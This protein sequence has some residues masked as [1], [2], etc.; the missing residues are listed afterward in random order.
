MMSDAKQGRFPNGKSRGKL[1]RRELLKLGLTGAGLSF[2]DFGCGNNSGGDPYK[3]PPGPVSIYKLSDGKTLYDDFDGNGGLQTYNGQNLAVAGKM[4]HNLWVGRPEDEVIS[5]PIIDLAGAS[6]V[7]ASGYVLKIT[8]TLQDF[9]F[10]NFVFLMLD[11][12][13]IIEFA[14]Y[15][16]FSADM[17]LS[18]A[19]T[20]EAMSTMLDYHTTIPEQFSGRSWAADIGIRKRASGEVYLFAAAYNVNTDYRYNVNMGPAELDRWYNL[21]LDV[22]TNKDDASFP[23]NQLRLDYYVDGVL[24]VSEIPIDAEILIDP[25]RTGGGPNRSLI[26]S[27]EAEVGEA[28][29]FFDNIR[30]AYRDRVS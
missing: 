16:T 27:K 21:R 15:K 19:S 28:I 6:A 14:E 29:A 7:G 13:T 5:N 22:V 25:A 9:T 3:P 30:A 26:V 24:I 1:T 20:V 11:N 10:G 2:L 18:S 4:S 8:N 12:P 17:L 23:A